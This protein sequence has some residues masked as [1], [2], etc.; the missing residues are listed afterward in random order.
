[1]CCVVS[2]MKRTVL[3]KLKIS[4]LAYDV[5]HTEVNYSCRKII[6]EI[7]MPLFIHPC[8]WFGL[9]IDMEVDI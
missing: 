1:M 9:Q 3:C 2:K 4:L 6:K 8:A 7:M 5:Y